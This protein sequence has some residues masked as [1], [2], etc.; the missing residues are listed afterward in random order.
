MRAGTRDADGTQTAKCAA[1]QS[2]S[3]LSTSMSERCI[4]SKPVYVPGE[5]CIV[6]YQ[7]QLNDHAGK[8]LPPSLVIGRVYP[9]QST[10]ATYIRDRLMPLAA[11]LRGR[12][13]IAPFVTPVALIEPL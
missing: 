9:T 13:E 11:Q 4:M 12:D 2:G 1:P 6:Q 10:C 7:L 8:P 5:C 3:A